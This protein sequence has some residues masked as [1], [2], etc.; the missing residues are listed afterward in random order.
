MNYWQILTTALMALLSR[1]TSFRVG[2]KLVSIS[3]GGSAVHLTLGAIIGA[4]EL[5]LG[6]Q[7]GT[8]QSGVFT[9]TISE[10]GAA[11]QVQAPPTATVRPAL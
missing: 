6:G 9:V 10:W 7:V 3:E 4:I 2:S 5:V 11:P 1:Q 8:V